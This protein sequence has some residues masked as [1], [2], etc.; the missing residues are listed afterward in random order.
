MFD[1]VLLIP[2]GMLR[3][4]ERGWL[5]ILGRVIWLGVVSECPR[6]E[7]EGYIQVI[8]ALL[9]CLDGEPQVVFAEGSAN[10]FFD[11]FRSPWCNIQGSRTVVTECV[12]FHWFRPVAFTTSELIL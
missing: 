9:V 7:V 10:Y 1:S 12:F 11:V 2:S 3:S 5:Y 8:H 4:I 6:T